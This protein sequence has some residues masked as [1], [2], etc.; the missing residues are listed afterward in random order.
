MSSIWRGTFKNVREAGEWH[1]KSVEGRNQ[2]KNANYKRAG[3]VKLSKVAF[4]KKL[5]EDLKHEER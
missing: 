1:L 4:R 5:L 3:K 2:Y